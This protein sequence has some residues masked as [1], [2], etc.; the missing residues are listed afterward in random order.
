MAHI[1]EI[2]ADSKGYGDRLEYGHKP[3][4]NSDQ[5]SGEELAT[6]DK[7][8]TDVISQVSPEEER[9]ILKKVDF[10]LVPVL[11]LLYLVAFIDRSNIGN[12]KI[13]G[14]STDLK[15]SGLQ[16]NTAVTMFFVSYGFFEVPSNIVLKIMRPSRW[17]AILMFCWG[18]VMTLMSIVKSREGLY[19]ARFCLG[20]AESGFFPAATY[21]LTIW[22]RRYEVQKRMAVFYTA[23]SL[24]GAFSGLLAYGIENM[25]GIDGLGGWRWIFMLE[26]LVPVALSLIIWKLLPDSPETASFL[27]K[28]EKEFIINRLALETGS[29]HGRVTNA[30]KINMKL[31]F[32]AFKEWRIY[33]AETPSVPM[34][35]LQLLTI[36]ICT[37]FLGR[38][39]ND[40]SNTD[41]FAMIM[42]LIFAFWSEHVQQRSPFIMAGFSIA[43]IGFIG[44]LVIPH[45]GLPGL[46]YGF[47]FPVAAGLYCPFIQIVCWIGNN[48]AP[49]SKRAVGM[50]LLISVGNFG[51]LAGSNIFLASEKPKYPAGF[52]T[53]LGISIAAILMAIV[54]RIS[55][56]R[57]NERRRVMIE[58]EGE[59]AIR[60]RYGEQQLLEMGDKSP[61]F[62]YTL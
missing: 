28:H 58:Q 25:A 47:L 62:I 9:R 1:Q 35:S 53:G 38:F 30:D 17:I 57:E 42:V 60:A 3:I 39:P 20:I 4:D 50:A 2:T 29:G 41:V 7:G 10:R 33:G 48:L 27:T 16:Y 36:P 46:T 55:C 51:G 37:Y 52:G 21:L 15:L 26:G 11:S 56:Q 49:S 59:D 18:V 14:L 24:S 31:I 23:A 5:S 6:L 12:A 22:Y 54:L 44:Q 45:P 34:A 32:A 43:A 19:A 61:F 40:C 8:F 13:A